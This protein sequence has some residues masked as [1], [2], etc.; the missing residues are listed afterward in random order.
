[1][2]DKPGKNVFPLEKCVGFSLKRLDIVKKIWGPLRKRFIPYC[3]KLVTGLLYD[4][5]R[6]QI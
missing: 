1:M 2:G 5:G 4:H 3:L 6:A